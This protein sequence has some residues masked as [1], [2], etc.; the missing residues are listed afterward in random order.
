MSW[1]IF[2][3]IPVPII[4]TENLDVQPG[5]EM[6]VVAAG[7]TSSSADDGSNQSTQ[8]RTTKKSKFMYDVFLFSGV[9]RINI[10]YNMNS[11]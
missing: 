5:D 4:F 7:G 11:L 1:G 3:F 6:E 8:K 10:Q 2:S 9:Y